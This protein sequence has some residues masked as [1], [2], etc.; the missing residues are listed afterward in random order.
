MHPEARL[1]QAEK[2]SLVS[3]LTLT[4]GADKGAKPKKSVYGDEI[5]D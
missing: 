5:N 4:I 3:G 2:D 1:S